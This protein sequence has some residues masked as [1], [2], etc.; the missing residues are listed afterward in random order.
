M[1]LGARYPLYFEEQIFQLALA[2]S[3]SEL[4][5]SVLPDV[6]RTGC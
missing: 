3:Q 4:A 6:F 1:L 5:E 2:A